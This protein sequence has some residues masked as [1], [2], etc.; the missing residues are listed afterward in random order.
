[1]YSLIIKMFT[2]KQTEPVW[3]AMFLGFI[4]IKGL[5]D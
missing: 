3:N 4:N 2:F 5:K 1:M